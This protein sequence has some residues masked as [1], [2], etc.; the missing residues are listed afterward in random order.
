M[1]ECLCHVAWARPSVRPAPVRTFQSVILS[2][3]R[4]DTEGGDR[5]RLR[6]P[7]RSKACCRYHTVRGDAFGYGRPAPTRRPPLCCKGTIRPSY[8]D[9]PDDGPP[10]RHPHPDNR[11]PDNRPPDKLPSCGRGDALECDFS[12]AAFGIRRGIKHIVL[13]SRK[14]GRHPS[15]DGVPGG[16]AF[17]SGRCRGNSRSLAPRKVY[18]EASFHGLEAPS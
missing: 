8:P 5:D 3:G 15:L 10:T 2:F 6:E 12:Y 17:A 13:P 7:A 4:G 16:V 18:R 11:P 1:L 9:N 14:L